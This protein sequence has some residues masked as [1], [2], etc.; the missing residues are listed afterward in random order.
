MAYGVGASSLWVQ[1]SLISWFKIS[2][3]EN[4]FLYS[5]CSCLC[6]AVIQSQF[7]TFQARSVAC[8]CAPGQAS[9]EHESGSWI[10]TSLGAAFFF[11]Y[12][13]SLFKL[14]SHYVS[15][16]VCFRSESFFFCFSLHFY[17]FPA[18]VLVKISPGTHEPL[19]FILYYSMFCLSLFSSYTGATEKYFP[20]FSLGDQ[21]RYSGRTIFSGRPHL[22]DFHFLVGRPSWQYDTLLI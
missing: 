21:I 1:F 13:A 18:Q 15:F 2:L 3:K 16:F 22:E 6:N 5:C 14:F 7:F 8:P 4:Q 17:R 19:S 11:Q 20:A 9:Q 12:R 10:V